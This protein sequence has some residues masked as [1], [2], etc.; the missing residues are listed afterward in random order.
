MVLVVGVWGLI[1][2]EVLDVKEVV[3][4]SQGWRLRGLGVSLQVTLLQT[5]FPLLVRGLDFGVPL[6]LCMSCA[7]H[8]V[9]GH[10]CDFRKPLRF[11]YA[12][13]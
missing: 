10:D 3:L 8:C 5:L 4:M 13:C 2:A 7:C 1:C 12:E 11:S 6:G 9:G